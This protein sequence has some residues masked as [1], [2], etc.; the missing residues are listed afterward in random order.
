MSQLY[1]STAQV[2][3][4][5][6]SPYPSDVERDAYESKSP[7]DEDAIDPDIQLIE[8]NGPDDPDNP[9]NWP[10]RRKVILTLVTLLGTLT[11]LINGT[12]I[13]V[14]AAEINEAFGISDANFPNSFWPV[15]SWTIGGGIFMI[16]LLP[17]MEVIGVRWGYLVTYFVFILFVVPQAVCQNFWTLVIVRFFAGGCVSLIANATAGMICDI[18]AGKKGRAA[19]VAGY[20]TCYLVGSSIGPVIGA[21]IIE[22]LHWRW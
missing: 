22:Y 20:V 10:F 12:S 4:A 6:T 13:T 14:A 16:T 7:S 9:F 5:A 3:D 18:W 17:M 8:W 15:T 1:G 19:P 2:N 11:V 21:A